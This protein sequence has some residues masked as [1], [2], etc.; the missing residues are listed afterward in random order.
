MNLICGDCLEEMSNIL[1]GSVDMICCDLPYG[2]TKNK[3]D[4]IIDLK[5]LWKQYERIIKDNGAIVLT[6]QNKFSARLILSNEKLH[7]YNLVWDK[8]LVSGFLNA[9]KMPL[10]VHEDII[11]FYKKL[12]VYNPQKVKG[13]VNH[14]KGRMKTNKNNNYGEYVVV[15]NHFGEMKHPKSLISFQKVHPSKCLH[16]TEKPVKLMEWLIKTYTNTGDLVLDN[17]MGS[18]TTI[19]ACLNLNRDFIGIEL[20]ERYFKSAKQRVENHIKKEE[21]CL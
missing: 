4:S 19:I 20:D 7:R 8:Q 21:L 12:P 18:G 16:A 5:K 9:N 2:I 3:W 17:C 6:G 14:S 15:D 13:Q 1:D 10:R 11:I